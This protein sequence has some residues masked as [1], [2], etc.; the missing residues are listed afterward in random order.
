M[1]FHRWPE[2]R[3]GETR[4][5][6]QWRNAYNRSFLRVNEFSNVVNSCS[7]QFSPSLAILSIN[8]F[9]QDEA[10]RVPSSL[11]ERAS[12]RT[13]RGVYKR[14]YGYTWPARETIQ[15]NKRETSRGWAKT[16]ER[17]TERDGRRL[18]SLWK[19]SLAGVEEL[20]A[21][22]SRGRGL[23]G[24]TAVQGCFARVPYQARVNDLMDHSSAMV[25]HPGSFLYDTRIVRGVTWPPTRPLCYPMRFLHIQRDFF[26]DLLHDNRLSRNHVTKDDLFTG[27][28][29]YTQ[30]RRK[31]E[32]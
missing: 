31:S 32:K 15:V 10:H 13:Q 24:R 8:T 25:D 2:G 14:E 23:P 17:W 21:M 11:T 30:N 1:K 16:R 12:V 3:R 19:G 20:Y 27:K 26:I 7:S 28:L 5:R 9:V 4:D 6:R 18:N 29:W 22:R